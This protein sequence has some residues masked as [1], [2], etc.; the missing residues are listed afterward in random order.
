MMVRVRNVSRVMSFLIVLSLLLGSFSLPAFAAGTDLSAEQRNA[1]SMLNY[2]TV[3]TQE[4]NSSKNSRLYMEEAYSSLIN[5]TYPNAVDNRTLSQLTGLLDIMEN[6]RMIS[7]KRERLQF[8][9]EQNQAQ[10]I[11]S[12][13]PNPL[14]L[15]SAVHSGNLLQLAASVAYMAVDSVTSY[16]TYTQQAELQYIQ[17]GWALDDEEANTLHESRKGTFSYMV[18][19]VQDYAIPGDITLTERTVE[20]YVKWKNNTNV[21]GRIQFLESNQSTYQGYS[22]YWLLLA[23]S[24]YDNGDYEKCLDA[25]SSYENSA[26]RIF[27]LDYDLAKVLPLAIAAAG[28]VYGENE[29]VEYA[30]AKA[31]TILSNTEHEDWALRYFVA[32]TYVDLYSRSND[33]SYL[34]AAYSIALDNVN[35][36][37]DEQRTLNETY[38]A[39]VQEASTPKDATKDEKK[40]ISD[41]N[42][43]LKETR[44]KELPPIY[45]PLQLNCDLLFALSSE[46]NIADNEKK[47]ITGI[48]HPNGNALFLTE[49]LDRLYWFDLPEE[50]EAAQDIDF[51]GTAIKIP[52]VYLADGADIQVTISSSGS[53]EP[54]VYSDWVVDKVTRG[55][56]ADIQEWEAIFTS[57]SI[58]KHDWK[59]DEQVV[60]VI[61]PDANTELDDTSLTFVT[62]GTKNAWYD[63]LKVWEGQNNEWYDYLKVWD[64]KVKFERLSE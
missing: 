3:L 21:T 17:D 18:K 8:I 56:S 26:A 7:V 37:V 6:Y 23:E 55:K 27:R 58:K 1:I 41:Y 33:A 52:V 5:N 46:K 45:E 36:L 47:K 30:A 15:M 11:R 61:N 51:A 40:Q 49:P 19:M 20:E 64:N 22:G 62:V 63:Y 9:Y 34:D 39:S 50:N 38:L 53:N 54:E 25:I 57:S 12:A 60:I 24:Y 10:A 2:I 14:G 43:M 16:N 31:K 48:L 32:Q 44:K 28:E 4:I 35:Y 42:K 59:P 29:Y 13:V